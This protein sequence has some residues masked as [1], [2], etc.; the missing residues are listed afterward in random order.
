M[1]SALII[2]GLTA[3]YVCGDAVR[4]LLRRSRKNV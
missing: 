1:M 2:L 4:A 3:G